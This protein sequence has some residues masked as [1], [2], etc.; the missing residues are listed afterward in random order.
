MGRLYL[1]VENKTKGEVSLKA[2]AVVASRLAAVISKRIF[3][4]LVI[5]CMCVC[6]CTMCVREDSQ[7]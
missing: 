6:M 1:D 7:Q 3:N 2:A 4:G 5:V